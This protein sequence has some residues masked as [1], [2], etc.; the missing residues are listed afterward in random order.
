MSHMIRIC[1][2]SSVDA[3]EIATL[4]LDPYRKQIVVSTRQGDTLLR[5]IEESEIKHY[6]DGERNRHRGMDAQIFSETEA[7][8]LLY[9]KL[10]RAVNNARS[11][12]PRA[13]PHPPIEFMPLPLLD[14]DAAKLALKANIDA[15]AQAGHEPMTFDTGSTLTRPVPM[16]TRE[17]MIANGSLMPA[18]GVSG[19]AVKPAYIKQTNREIVEELRD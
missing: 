18:S 17:R 15:F 2:G 4:V 1:E 7:M 3:D 19:V 11:S 5:A 8:R 13:W 12:E 14:E 6:A 10:L 16:T 9:N